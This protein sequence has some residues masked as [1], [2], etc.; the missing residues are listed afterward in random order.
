MQTYI[1][2]DICPNQTY[3]SLTKNQNNM[4][5]IVLVA[6]VVA[7]ATAAVTHEPAFCFQ[8]RAGACCFMSPDQAGRCDGSGSCV[9]GDCDDEHRD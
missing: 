2:T 5:L 6:S 4:K 9:D 7:A 8:K 1:N 3:S